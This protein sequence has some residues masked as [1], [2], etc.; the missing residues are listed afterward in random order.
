MPSAKHLV[1]MMALTASALGGTS[2]SASGDS[3]VTTTP[4][5]GPL[6][7]WSQPDNGETLADK[8]LYLRIEPKACGSS[9]LATV[10]LTAPGLRPQVIS[11]GTGCV[12]GDQPIRFSGAFTIGVSASNP[13]DRNDFNDLCAPDN[14]SIISVEVGGE[15]KKTT[16][17]TLKWA[18]AVDGT[19]VT[20]GSA[21]FTRSVKKRGTKRSYITTVKLR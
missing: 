19:S 12:F 11:S 4:S 3:S 9:T 8:A 18:L 1:L 13:L 7:F 21:L 14:C 15:P 2:A 6:P 16:K 5:V 20:S 10:R 17:S